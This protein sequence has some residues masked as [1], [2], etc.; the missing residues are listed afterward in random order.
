M[1][2]LKGLLFLFF[3]LFFSFEAHALDL[4]YP[5]Q[6]MSKPECRFQ[7]FSTLNS[8]CKMDLPILKTADYIKYKNDYNLYRRVYTVLWA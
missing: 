3:M 5:I 8:D 7:K 6:E 2:Y 4:V 1:K